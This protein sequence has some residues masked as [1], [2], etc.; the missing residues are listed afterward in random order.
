MRHVA[1][2]FRGAPLLEQLVMRVYALEVGHAVS[3][4]P[5]DEPAARFIN[6]SLGTS[7]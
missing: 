2:V 3:R 4:L 6:P 1:E 7:L 5:Y